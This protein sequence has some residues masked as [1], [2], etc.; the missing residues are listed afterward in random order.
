MKPETH[1]RHEPELESAQLVQLPS[2]HVCGVVVCEEVVEV[3]VDVDVDVD[4]VDVLVRVVV[5]VE[6]P[7]AARVRNKLQLERIGTCDG[8]AGIRAGDGR[9]GVGHDE[10]GLA[11]AGEGPRAVQRLGVV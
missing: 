7:V 6:V 1:V 2:K 11:L 10:P 5:V 3:D 4:V 8:G 9:G